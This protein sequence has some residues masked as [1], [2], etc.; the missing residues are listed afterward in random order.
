MWEDMCQS[1]S[2]GW[3]SSFQV[4]LQPPILLRWGVWG[5]AAPP[6]INRFYR[7]ELCYSPMDSGQVVGHA[8]G[9][10]STLLAKVGAKN[11]VAISE[12][13]RRIDRLCWCYYQI[14][15]KSE[16]VPLDTIHP[17]L[18]RQ[19]INTILATWPTCEPASLL[20]GESDLPAIC[21]GDHPPWLEQ[22]ANAQLLH[23]RRHKPQRL[24][25]HTRLPFYRKRPKFILSGSVALGGW[26]AA[27]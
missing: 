2:A 18:S 12:K 10:T 25:Q 21:A 27:G 3:L 17:R 8:T 14:G 23:W 19:E 24:F 5:K 7:E 9:P 6:R 16:V 26:S 1:R 22:V 13:F 4:A 15:P 20:S 11:L